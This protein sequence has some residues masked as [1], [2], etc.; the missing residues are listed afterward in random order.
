MDPPPG[1]ANRPEARYTG[2]ADGEPTL[3]AADYAPMCIPAVLRGSHGFRR[4]HVY[5]MKSS[6]RS[7]S[8]ARD[9]RRV[10]TRAR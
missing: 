8:S 6:T 5:K 10:G 2:D 3:D 7:L 9:E 4:G 1:E